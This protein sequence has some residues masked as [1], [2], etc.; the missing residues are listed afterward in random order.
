MAGETPQQTIDNNNGNENEA[1]LQ[2]VET[3][4][5]SLLDWTNENDDQAKDQIRN[6]RDDGFKEW[7][8]KHP[9][10][11]TSLKESV[12]NFIDE[13]KKQGYKLN[14]DDY[15]NLVELASALGISVEQTLTSTDVTAASETVTNLPEP[16][17]WLKLDGDPKDWWDK[18]TTTL[19]SELV[20]EK[21]KEW[22]PD[23]NLEG[24]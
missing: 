14:D 4:I 3:W 15:K 13:I 20:R 8:K 17:F 11:V 22:E 19:Y 18:P 21:P 10:K 23:N 6:A 24:K 9:D 5:K 7:V 2:A 12:Q 1:K 16:N